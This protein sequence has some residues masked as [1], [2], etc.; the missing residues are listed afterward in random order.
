MCAKA[1]TEVRGQCT[2]VGPVLLLCVELG[3]SGS[4][5]T[6]LSAELSLLPAFVK[7]S[8]L[9]QKYTNSELVRRIACDKL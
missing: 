3:L 6:V 9:L 7:C 1:H 2:G 4:V 5:A 8:Y